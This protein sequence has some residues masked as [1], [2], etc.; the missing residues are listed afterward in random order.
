MYKLYA[1]SILLLA[2]HYDVP[3]Q[4]YAFTP[5]T[6]TYVQ[7]YEGQEISGDTAYDW[8]A[9]EVPLGFD[10]KF[11]DETTN[12]LYF[13]DVLSSGG[14]TTS[15]SRDADG[16]KLETNYL[17]PFSEGITDP[18]YDVGSTNQSNSPIRYHLIGEAPSRI[19]ILQFSNAAPREASLAEF[20]INL[21]L[22]LYEADGTIEVHYGPSS[23]GLG[24]GSN[25]VS[26]SVQLIQNYRADA[27]SEEWTDAYLL[28]GTVAEAT[29]TRYAD[30]D[31]LPEDPDDFRLEGY[32]ASGTVYRFVPSVPTGVRQSALEPAGRL[33]AF[34]NPTADLV[35]LRLPEAVAGP[36]RSL[37]VYDAGGR[38]V[39][40]QPLYGETFHL[41][42]LPNGTYQLIVTDASGRAYIGRV[43]KR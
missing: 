43:M 7:M 14:L 9:Y 25:R 35:H 20:T 27:T 5:L 18:R 26:S 38:L 41:G 34:P 33:T 17:I 36:A 3:A 13:S 4:A 1:T 22:W 31:Q 16:K 37:A 32:P 11:F 12:T 30:A 40:G 10:F 2:I 21:Q 24:N 23:D 39:H 29:L 28:T 8:P 6:A 42:E 19:G 15:P